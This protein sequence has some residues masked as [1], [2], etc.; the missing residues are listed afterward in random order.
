MKKNKKAKIELQCSNGKCNKIYPITNEEL[1][2]LER[3]GE[4]PSKCPYCEATNTCT[5]ENM[6]TGIE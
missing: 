1:K 3:A 6:R 4:S 5:M 2:A